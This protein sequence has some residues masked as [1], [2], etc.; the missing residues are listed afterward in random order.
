MTKTK[1]ATP[2]AS[3]Q[4][5]SEK[6]FQNDIDILFV[7]GSLAVGG[8][9]RHLSTLA[10][11]LA[12]R[13]HNV[14]I[15][16]LFEKGPLNA[17]TKNCGVRVMGPPISINPRMR[18]NLFRLLHM[19]PA[20]LRL[21]VRLRARKPD[22]L[23]LFGPPAYVAGG[24]MAIVAGTPRRIMSRRSLNTYQRGY[25]LLANFERWLH[26]RMTAILGNSRAVLAQ[27]QNEELVPAQK[28]A[29]IYNG[30]DLVLFDQPFNR[31]SVR[32]G[33]A[34]GK[35]DLVFITVANLIPYKGHSDLLRA[36][37]RI[38]DKLPGNWKLW[39]VGRDDGIGD[40][41]KRQGEDL[42]VADHLRFLDQRQDVPD[43]LRSADIALSG[44]HEEGFSNAILESMA[45]SLPVIATDVGGN[46]EAVVDDVTGCLV[47]AKDDEQLASA[48]LRVAGEP[49]LARRMG[50][51]GR[52]RVNEHFELEAC[53]G[54]YETLYRAIMD[55]EPIVIRPVDAAG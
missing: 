33:V 46:R 44:S 43:L 51:A 55:G 50:Q 39:I 31:Q 28:L 27:L 13:G 36:F 15:Y 5:P 16:C 34:T 1:A 12:S 10:R 32:D 7:I 54:K 26:R 45:A 6:A 14:T 23:H 20:G 8:M 41:L 2:K 18:G 38:K 3:L 11:R 17:E 49:T 29:L 42:G 52:K 53:V 9:E 30:I 47:P 35:N 22:I 37:A 19:A 21:L 40:E 48:M 25:P 4:N 24:L